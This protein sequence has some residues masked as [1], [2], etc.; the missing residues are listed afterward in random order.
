MIERHW[1]GTCKIEQASNYTMHLLHDT[2][3]LL[4]GMEGF[5]KATILKRALGNGIEFLIVTVWQSID[6]IKQFAGE[7]VETA[8]VPANVQQMMVAFDKTVSHYE[9]AESY[10]SPQ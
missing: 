6:A 7:D 3:P 10:L 5:V 4:A 8:V 2:F 1:K 9:V